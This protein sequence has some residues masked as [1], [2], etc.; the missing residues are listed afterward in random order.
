MKQGFDSPTGYQNTL[1]IFFVNHKED[2]LFSDWSALTKAYPNI[3]TKTILTAGLIIIKEHKLLLAFS[4]NK[5]AWYLPGGK[6]DE[7]ETSLQAIQ[8][9]IQEE[10]NIQLNTQMLTYHGHI[11]APAY[12]EENVLMEQDCFLYPATEEITPNGEIEA[13]DYFSLATNKKESSQV[14][15]V[16]QVFEMLLSSGLIVSEEF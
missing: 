16:L 4:R 2:F 7:G 12:G 14:V 15:G 1:K 6:A 8:R 3:K 13:V 9:E 10:L 5:K 11:T